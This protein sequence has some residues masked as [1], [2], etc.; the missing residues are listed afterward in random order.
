MTS[1]N[2]LFS[3]GKSAPAVPQKIIKSFR[4]ISIDPQIRS[5]WPH[6]KNTR[7]LVTDVFKAQVKG[8]SFESLLSDFKEMGIKIDKKALEEAYMFTIEWLHYLNAKKTSRT[9]Y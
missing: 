7:I 5:G 6:I 8:S 4:Y 1:L 2:A 9:S 3:E